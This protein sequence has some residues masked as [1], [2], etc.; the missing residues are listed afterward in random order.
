[1]IAL[2][3]YLLNM[4]QNSRF[5]LGEGS[6]DQN[7]TNQHPASALY[8]NAFVIKYSSS[9]PRY[10]GTIKLYELIIFLSQTA[11]AKTKYKIKCL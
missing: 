11:Y 2:L 7:T 10:K 8:F 4:Q 9:N 3:L 6:Y 1:M 5:S